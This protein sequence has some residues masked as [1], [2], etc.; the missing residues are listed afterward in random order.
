MVEGRDHVAARERLEH[1][2]PDQAGA[3]DN[4]HAIDGAHARNTLRHVTTTPTPID[5]DAIMAEVRERVRQKRARGIYG[6]E[7]EAALHAPLPGGPLLSDE[8]DDPLT[9]LSEALETEA[10]YDVRSRRGPLGGPITF[11]RKVAIWLIRWY[12]QAFV[13][14][15]EHMN[16]LIVRKLADLDTQLPQGIGDRLAAL[17]RAERARTVHETAS[18]MDYGLFAERFGGLESQVRAQA[19][20]HVRYF[21]GCSRVLDL[22]S[23]RGTFLRL[24]RER[25]IGAYGVDLA[26]SLVDRSVAEGLEAYTI[27]AEQHL[28]SLP[29]DSLDGIFAVHIAEHVEPGHLLE[30]LHECKRVLRS[31]RSLVMATPNPHTLTVGAHL[32]WL[33]PTHRKP[34]PPD[35]FQFYLQI[36]GFEPVTLDFYN[37]SEQR[38]SDDGL[39]GA[40]LENARLLNDTLFGDRDYA[41]IGRKP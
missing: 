26:R 28:R 36:S 39:T 17:E 2:P 1:V 32:F 10:A 3:A 37:P 7:V 4:E 34:L 16:A 18:H 40:A 19:E 20:R 13:S 15:Q 31:G 41:V 30:L 6:P 22:G 29:A 5:V 23:G 33:D 35:A 9:A 27:D 8:L 24:A 25:G 11:A 12:V 14:R 38:L 21:E